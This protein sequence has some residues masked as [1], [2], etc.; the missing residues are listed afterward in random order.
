MDNC[1]EKNYFKLCKPI[2]D[3]LETL[4]IQTL[5]LDAD[6]IVVI[7]DKFGR[8]YKQQITTASNGLAVIDLQ[9]EESF[10]EA[11]LNPYSGIFFLVVEDMVGNT[12]PFV[13]D[14][15][16]YDG[17]QIEVQNVM[18]KK[19]SFYIDAYDTPIGEY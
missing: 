1:C 9:E 3:C 10:P 8:R 13:I 18:P 16:S 6:V 15:V 11:L 7:L 14:G 17:L 12:I 4:N 2:P 19:T 5:S